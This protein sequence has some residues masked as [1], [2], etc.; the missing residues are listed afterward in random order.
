MAERW[1]VIIGI[2]NYLHSQWGRVPYAEADAAAI[3]A[4]LEAAG[5]PAQ[6]QLRLTGPFAT[7]A[8]VEARLKRLRKQVKKGD[9]L[10]AFWAGR[11]LSIGGRGVLPC[12]DTL[13]DDLA[14][15]ALPVA[16]WV[17][18]L[19][20]TKA[21][22]VVFLLAV[23]AGTPVAE[24]APCLDGD[25][26]HRLF[27]DTPKAVALAACDTDEPAQA[28]PAV[29]HSLWVQLVAE[30][31]AGQARAATRHG[32]LTALSLQRFIEDELPRRLRKHCEAGIRQ[33]PQLYGESNA[34]V[35][36]AD[37]SATLSDKQAEAVL[38]PGRL[39]RVVFRSE[40]RIRVRDLRDFRKSY[41]VPD[42]AGPSARKFIARIAAADIRADLDR[43][44]DAARD[45]LGTK[46]KDLDLSVGQDGYGSLRT[47][48]FEYTV[49]VDL[50]PD[51]PSRVSWRREAGHFPD[52]AFL[53]GPQFEAVF[54]STFDQLVFEFR[55]PVNVA[56][57]VDRIEDDPPPGVKLSVASDGA[58]C[59]ISLAGFAG[60]VTVKRHALTVRGRSA[61]TAGLFDLFLQF[62]RT[63][64]SLGDPPALRAKPA[65]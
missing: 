28:A 6:Q 17:H 26:L 20:A 43:V 11:G 47:P 59:D 57:F 2:E 40:A 25:E 4:A 61:T 33:T 42:N 32:Q 55:R 13:P 45:A 49:V 62:L 31:I 50:D 21:S 65:H 8:A 35:V 54:G 41:Q 53:R 58:A 1:A 36:I 52:P 16:D 9:D 38:D 30:A 29:K 19:T 12:W 64:G 10:L 22:Q 48:D 46:R 7:K 5:Y 18:A 63:F 37:L 27:A 24:A 3:A 60:V 34:A 44:Y 23:G 39:R 14:E 51:D 15:T 56:D